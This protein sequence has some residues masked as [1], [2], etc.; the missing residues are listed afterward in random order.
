FFSHALDH[1]LYGVSG[2]IFNEL[3]DVGIS[4]PSSWTDLRAVFGFVLDV[5]GI[6]LAH[7]FELLAKRLTPEQVAFLRSSVKILTG[8][9]E[10]VSLAIREGLASVAKKL[11][12]HLGDLGMAVLNAAVDWILDQIIKAVGKKLLSMMDPTGIMAVVNSM[13]AVYRAIQTVVRYMA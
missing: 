9:W 4:P 11:V 3:K 6:S 13:I 7:V 10:W 8:V 2:W 5:L 12:E 1:L